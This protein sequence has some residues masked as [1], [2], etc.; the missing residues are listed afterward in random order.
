MKIKLKKVLNAQGI[1]YILLLS[2]MQVTCSE[3]GRFT[4]HFR[5]LPY[6]DSTN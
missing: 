3:I 2:K 6:F 5:K 4:N 1:I